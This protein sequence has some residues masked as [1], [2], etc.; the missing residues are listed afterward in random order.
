MKVLDFG[1]AK[2]RALNS[3]RADVTTIAGTRQGVVMG[4]AASW[5]RNRPA[6]RPWITAPTSGAS[7]WF[8][9]N[10]SRDA[11]SAGRPAARRGIA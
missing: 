4:T 11:A 1:L 2:M 7:A 6:A 10:W 9:T 3:H 5:R 8:S